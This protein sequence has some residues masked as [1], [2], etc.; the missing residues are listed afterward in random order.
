MHTRAGSNHRDPEVPV[1]LPKPPAPEPPAPGGALDWSF[2]RHRLLVTCERAVF[3]R[4]LASRGGFAEAAPPEARRAWVLKHL[5]AV[6][7][8]IGTVVHAAARRAVVAVRRGDALPSHDRLL[9]DARFTMNQI[10]RGSQRDLIDRFWRWPGSHP[11]LLE[12]VYRGTLRELELVRAR[13]KLDRCVTHLVGCTLWDDL[14]RAGDD[15]Y[16]DEGI[17]VA[18]AVGH[19]AVWAALD[20]AYQHRATETCDQLVGSA[21]WCVA[22][23]KT[24]STPDPDAERLQLGVYAGVLASR[25]MRP[26]AGLYLGRIV[27]LARGE[28]RWYRLDAAALADARRVIGEDVERQRRLLGDLPL[29]VSPFAPI[30][31]ILARKDHFA[32]AADR[33]FCRSC[34]FFALCRAELRPLRE[35]IAQEEGLRAP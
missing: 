32:L 31:G 7:L 27:D 13:E 4:Y 22:D 15:V 29:P 23:F 30:P 21:T 35:R 6:P 8:L 24:T 11:A 5:T 9:A 2:S 17:P 25:G 26:T 14:R 18:S 10:W 1:A 16:I 33:G 12:I 3:W 20:L 28:D 34:A 19:N